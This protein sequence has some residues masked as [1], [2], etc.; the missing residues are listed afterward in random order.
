MSLGI[1]GTASGHRYVERRP[2]GPLLVVIWKMRAADVPWKR[3]F[4]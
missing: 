2:I 3:T 1:D 4:A